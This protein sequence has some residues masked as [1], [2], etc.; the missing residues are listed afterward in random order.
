MEIPDGQARAFEEVGFGFIAGELN[1]RADD[2]SGEDGHGKKLSF[3]ENAAEVF[4]KHR[5][6][7]DVRA[8]LGDVIDAAFEGTGLGT[9]RA[10]AFGKDDNGGASVEGFNDGRNGIG[11]GGDIFAFDEEGVENAHGRETANGA[12]IPVI[13]RGDGAGALADWAGEGSPEDSG[14]EVA[15]V[16]GEVNSGLSGRF[17]GHP[18]GARAGDDAKES[19]IKAG[20]HFASSSAA[21]REVRR[22][23]VIRQPTQ[24]MIRAML[25]TDTELR[26]VTLWMNP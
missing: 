6:Q 1:G 10:A 3:G 9:G 2:D 25:I 13:L 12:G 26:A 21:M 7:R 19:R 11:A 18:G 15:G 16:V 8:L 22:K 24:M 4:E 14:V 17:A 5:S 20:D 23:I